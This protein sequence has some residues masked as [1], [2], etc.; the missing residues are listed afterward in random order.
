MP[1]IPYADVTSLPA[2]LLEWHGKLPPNSHLFQMVAHASAT[3]G[4]LMQLG[5][6][7]ITSL[8]LSPRLRELAA[9]ATAAV[10]GADYLRVRHLPPGEPITSAERDALYAGDHSGFSG[11]DLAVVTFATEVARGSKVDDATFA[12]VRAALSEREIVELI[13]VVGYYWLFGQFAN[14]LELDAEPYA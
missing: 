12:P 7:Q 10:L 3:G 5:S 8:E 6:R 1:R 2:D 14:V 4:L 11:L 13:Q 9:N